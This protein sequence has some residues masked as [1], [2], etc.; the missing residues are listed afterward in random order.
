MGSYFSLPEWNMNRELTRKVS[1][2][3]H[4]EIE[5]EL[6]EKTEEEEAKDKSFAWIEALLFCIILMLCEIFIVVI[7]SI[8]FDYTPIEEAL[9]EFEHL[10]YLYRDVAIMIFFGFGFLMTFPRRYGYSSIGMT[11]LLASFVVQWSIICE[12]FFAA[13]D[14]TSHF[15]ERVPIGIH[16]ILD[17]M[18][19]SGAVLIS[20]GAIL[21]KSTPFQLTVMVVIEPFFFWLIFFICD[22]KLHTV[23]IGGGYYIHMYGA[24]FGLAVCFFLTNAHAKKHP[25]NI[26]C[27]TSDLFAFAGCLFLWLLWPS[28]NAAIAP[29]GIERVRAVINT[30]LSPCGA[31]VMAF[32]VSRI[33]G[34]GRFDPVHIQ[35][36]TLAGGVI[37][38]IAAHLNLYPAT[39]IAC[40]MIAG[41]ISTL[42]Y[43][44]LTPAMAHFLHLHDTCGVHNL[45]G[46]PGIL[47]AVVSIFATLGI[48]Q[49]ETGYIPEYE[50]GKYQPL[51][52]LAAIGITLGIAIA[53]GAATGLILLGL[54]FVR[55]IHKRDYYNDREFWELPSDYE[56]YSGLSTGSDPQE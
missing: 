42:G 53:A 46:M 25:D 5:R 21:G 51:I 7:Y 34:H 19:C 11:F 17:G 12:V 36:A 14:E 3:T 23:D 30:L 24:Y 16:E 45:H 37:M 40:G 31:T 29:T 39:A 47:G 32:V 48:S 56:F 28:F 15:S 13:L 35:N 54:S 33:L 10:Y 52:Q 41:G 22:L 50:H 44:F 49:N 43:V 1:S 38:G 9:F 2:I 27:Y 18:F 4:I 55:R 26:A 8:W 6:P 20:L